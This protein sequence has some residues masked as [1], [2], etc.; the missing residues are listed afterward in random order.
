MKKR[1]LI[2]TA[3]AITMAG[4]VLLPVAGNAQVQAPIYVVLN[5]APLAFSGT[6]PLQIKGST[7]VPMRGIFEALGATVKFDKASLTVYG[8]KGATAIILPLGALTATVNGQPQ[9]LPQAAQLI[10]GTTLVPLRFISQALGASVS[11]NP[12]IRTVT[13]LTVDQHVGSLPVVPGSGTIHGEVT[14]LYTNTTPTQLTVRVGGRNTTIPLSDSTV[15]LRSV[16]HDPATQV[17]LDQIKPGDQVTV[18]RGDNGV[19]TVITANFGQVKGTIVSIGHLGNGDA[20]L[21]LDSG[22]VIELASDAPITFGGRS[23]ALSDIKPYETVVI[24]TNPSNSLGYGVAVSTATNPNPTPP[25]QAPGAGILNGSVS[26]VE[27]TSFTQDAEK[28]LRAGD[29][30]KATLSGT[31]G[32][33]ASF[34]I[35]GIAD[36]IPMHETSPGVYTGSY[37]VVRN[38]SA[39]GAAVLGRLVAGG[40]QSALIQAPGMLTIDSQPPKI[41]DFGPAQN[42]LVESERPLVYATLTD[43]PGVGV[44]P[45]ATHISVDGQ[46]VTANADITGSLFTYKPG[47]PLAGGPHTVNVVIADKAGNSTTASWGFKVSTSKIV[48]SFTT[49]EPSGKAVGAGSTVVFTLN[50]APGGKAHA[51][52]GNLAKDI[53][54]QETD[55]GVYVGEYTVKAGDSVQNAPVTARFVARDGTAVTKNLAT[56]LT[57][58]AGPPPAPRIVS[59]KD[60]DYIDAGSPLTVKGRALPGSTVRVA[61]SYTSKAL[62]GILPVSGQSATKDVTVDKNGDWTAE[63]LSLQVKSLF[64]TNRDTIFTVTATQL[65]ASG[66]AASDPTTIQVRPN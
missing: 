23:V 27:V 55:P 13:I 38:A 24:R 59:P 50:A 25:G 36:D 19:A 61:V 44:N 65:N 33:K 20:A 7:L 14:G 48:Q 63:D 22:R 5:G 47:T 41:T 30:L 37:T 28:P 31:P 64:G 15:I 8:Q 26:T 54:M 62:G 9:S 46:D 57:I 12:A 53:P 40:V 34:A 39:T 51:D 58:S 35:P 21:T 1:T 29:V 43:G 45:N 2:Q 42:S 66:S 18:Q 16:D 52:V 11:W 3:A 32:G 17:A 4:T 60:S 49:N 10:N 6:P 56:D